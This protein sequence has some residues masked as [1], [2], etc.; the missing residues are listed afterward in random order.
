APNHMDKPHA[1][2]LALDVEGNADRPEDFLPRDRRRWV[3]T[4]ENGRF[5]EIT[6][7]EMPRPVSPRAQP[8]SVGPAACDIAGYTLILFARDDRPHIRIVHSWSDAQGLRLGCELIEE[9]V[10]NGAIE[11][12]A[13]RR[14]THLPAIL[15]GPGKRV[16][17]GAIN[18]GISEDD[19]RVLAAELQDRR[20]DPGCG[21]G[22]YLTPRLQ[23]AGEA[24]AA[25]KRVAHQRL[26][27]IFP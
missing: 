4:L 7:L 5:D 19:H 22:K 14:R 3:D 26:A 8:R 6:A 1:P 21:A 12:I 23:R 13:R 20:F 24:D 15:E 25:H 18:I 16:A 27:G 17:H 10:A 2:R 9:L 11:Q